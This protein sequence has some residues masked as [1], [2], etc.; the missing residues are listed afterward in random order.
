M[1]LD[2]YDRNNDLLI[3]KNTYD[4]SENGQFR[5]SRTDPKA[6]EDLYFVHIEV[7]DMNNLSDQQERKAMMK[8]AS[9]MKAWMKEPESKTSN[10]LYKSN[11]IYKWPTFS[12]LSNKNSNLF[13][14]LK[15][16]L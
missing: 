5:I 9:M 11:S 1:V 8:E 7:K 6:P 13:E 16:Y 14:V 4:D 2:T 15:L 10:D 12:Q 3:F